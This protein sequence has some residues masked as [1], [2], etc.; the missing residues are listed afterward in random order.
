MVNVKLIVLHN[1]MHMIINVGIVL[2]LVKHVQ[3]LFNLN[4]K[5]VLKIIIKYRVKKDAYNVIVIVG[6]VN[7]LLNTAY[8]AKSV[9]FYTRIFV[10]IQVTALIKCFKI[11]LREHVVNK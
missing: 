6:N 5:L 10:L 3:K 2:H 1:I 8:H 4:V 7:Q 11:V 9:H